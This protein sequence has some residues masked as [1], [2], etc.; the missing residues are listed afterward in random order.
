MKNWIVALGFLSGCAEN[1]APDVGAGDVESP[2]PDD[3]GV[4]YSPVNPGPPTPPPPVD[5]NGDDLQG[6]RLLGLRPDNILTG[7]RYFRVGTTA[8]A[9][10]G[11]TYSLSVTGAGS[12][13][14]RGANL[15]GVD[16]GTTHIGADPWFEGLVLTEVGGTGEL[17]IDAAR[18]SDIENSA[19]YEL[20]YRASPSAS[21]QPYC[22]DGAGALAFH[23]GFTARRVHQAGSS[24]TFGCPDGV[25]YK[26]TGWG[27]VAG[28][29]GDGDVNWDHHQACI[30]M[31][32]AAYCGGARSF[33][34]EQTPIQIADFIEDYGRPRDVPPHAD[35]LPGD[36][37]T[38][39]FEAGWRPGGLP[40]LCLSKF[41]WAAMPPN[42]CPLLLP[43]PRYDDDEDARYCE[44][45]PAWELHEE[46]VLLINGSKRMDA[47]LV[48]WV[49]GS[50]NVV[51]TIRGFVDRRGGVI[52]SITP[53]FPGYNTPNAPDGMILRNLPGTLDPDIDM[54]PLYLHHSADG[55]RH[56]LSD[57]NPIAGFQYD[58]EVDFEG[59]A[60]KD[61]QRVPDL[62]RL[63]VCPTAS[64]YRTTLTPCTSS[65]TGPMYV[66]RAP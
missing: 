27:Y 40:P 32:N 22:T 23:G 45:I 39:Y 19:V 38:H 52:T 13:G 9:P 3:I 58:P 31:A 18:P 24:I 61:E 8:I 6:R 60:F 34:R 65:I 33:T 15:V 29:A 12:L 28:T 53:P 47:P 17:R 64:G 54:I 56:V 26:C 35:P 25:A 2:P 7:G 41:R 44:D 30:Q 46:G 48:P 66:M 49:D 43:D 51:S 59:Y 10:N 36:P 14:A 20:S 62:Q 4:M 42:P 21:W 5:A 16:G 37:D 50:G 55:K 57:G 1:V 11:N 63:Y